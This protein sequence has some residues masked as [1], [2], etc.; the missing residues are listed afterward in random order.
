M[1]DREPIEVLVDVEPSHPDGGM[2]AGVGE[3][4]ELDAYRDDD[5]EPPDQPP[6]AGVSAPWRDSPAPA[7]GEPVWLEAPAA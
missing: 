7:G 3:L 4:I 6:A 5:D 2:S 1:T